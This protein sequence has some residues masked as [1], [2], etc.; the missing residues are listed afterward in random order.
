[1]KDL[2]SFK[3]AFA[4]IGKNNC[5]GCHEKYRLKKS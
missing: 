4:N 2:E 3:A 5:G 1:V